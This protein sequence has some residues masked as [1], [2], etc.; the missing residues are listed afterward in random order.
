[1][2]LDSDDGLIDDEERR[3]QEEELL[4]R[5]AMAHSMAAEESNFRGETPDG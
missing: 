5:L 3:I 2:E 1:L 4:D